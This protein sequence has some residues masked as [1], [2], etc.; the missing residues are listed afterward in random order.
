MTRVLLIAAVV[1]AAAPPAAAQARKGSWEIAPGAVWFSGIDLG[2]SA[3]TLERP[4]GGEFELFTTNTRIEPALGA[5]ATIS[6]FVRPRLA[7]EAGVSYARPNAATRVADD[8]ENAAPLTATV[9]L[10]QYLIE[11]NL[12]WYLARPRAGWRPFL[13][14]GGGYLRQLDDSSAH[15][16]TGAVG[17][18]G[19]GA[20]RAFRERA[21]GRLRRIG[22]R[23]DARVQ[24][25][26]GGF[27]VNDTLRIGFAAGALMFFGL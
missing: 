8:A 13:R 22:L 16:E 23:L 7:V 12:R 27:D 24:G 9:G 2:G 10:Q 15:V 3:A 6:F 1:L 19:L 25:R 20:D 11:G 26:S 18:A 21:A 17:Q 5:A 4:G 14:G